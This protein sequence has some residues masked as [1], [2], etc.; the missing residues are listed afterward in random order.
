MAI[1]LKTRNAF[2]MT[3][4]EA[5]CEIQARR[6]GHRAFVGVY[7]PT[8]NVPYWRVRKIRDSGRSG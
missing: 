5:A 7:P 8:E 1:T 4:R 2:E 6:P 3:R